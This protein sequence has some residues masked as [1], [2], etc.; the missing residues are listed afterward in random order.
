M[1]FQHTF[2]SLTI[3][4][5]Y[6]P[7]PSPPQGLEFLDSLAEVWE[8][9]GF[10][11][12]LFDAECVRWLLLLLR[13]VDITGESPALHL[14]QFL[15][16][17]GVVKRYRQRIRNHVSWRVWFCYFLCIYSMTCSSVHKLLSVSEASLYLCVHVCR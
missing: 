5:S 15:K 17:R 11:G 12:Q 4:H 10:N 6:F 1:I 16:G 7:S 2:H 3:F 9:R 13:L 14:H 8:R